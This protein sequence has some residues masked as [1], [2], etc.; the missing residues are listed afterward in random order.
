MPVNI[1]V[2]DDLQVVPKR[3]GLTG[4][5]NVIEASAA[6]RSRNGEAEGL[7]R[8]DTGRLLEKRHE[9]AGDWL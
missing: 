3:P 7:Q 1:N 9:L 2:G 6:G 4:S 5:T 8:P